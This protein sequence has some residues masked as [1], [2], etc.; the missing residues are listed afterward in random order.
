MWLGYYQ[1]VTSTSLETG[2]QHFNNQNFVILDICLQLTCLDDKAKVS[3]VILDH[4]LQSKP[5]MS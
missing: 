3:P 1:P 4:I 2:V 5:I